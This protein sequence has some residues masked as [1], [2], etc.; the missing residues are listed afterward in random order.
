MRIVL[1]LLISM[2]VCPQKNDTQAAF[3]NVGSNAL[4]GGIGALIN[5]NPDEKA[6]KVFFKGIY[7]GALGG[8]LTFESKRLV[9]QFY[10]TDNYAYLW[11]SKLLNSAGNSITYNA[12]SNRNFWERWHMDFGFNYLEYDFKRK[13][14][15]RYR[16]LPFALTGNI[17]GF[18]TSKFDFK[19]TLYTGHFIFRSTEIATVGE[20]NPQGTTLVNTM[21]Y[22]RDID[23][24]LEGVLAH[25]L[26]H[27][28][29]YTGTFFINSYLQGS[30][31]NLEK[32]SDF[33]K[34]YSKIF[35]TDLSTPLNQLLYQIQP[36]FGVEYHDILQEK[37]ADYYS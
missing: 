37:E 31:K 25:E 35:Y 23:I 2:Y 16:I 11:P 28:Y 20:R 6:S 26:I 7:Q 24:D 36:L 19:R 27:V 8:Y 14:R 4:I 33:Y 13:R 17:Y 5:K 22:E 32:N 29:Q 10:K 18:A 1:I 34:K 3:Y 9:R 15:L 30:V 21:Q 12:A